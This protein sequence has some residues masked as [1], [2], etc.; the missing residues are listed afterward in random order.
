MGDKTGRKK[1]NGR[2]LSREASKLK[3]KQEAAAKQNARPV[4]RGPGR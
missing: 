4:L 2:K 3:R 1:G